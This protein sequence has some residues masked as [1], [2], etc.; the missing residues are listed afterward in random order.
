MVRTHILNAPAPSPVSSLIWLLW[1][2][3]PIENRNLL[4]TSYVIIYMR[5]ELGM[6]RVSACERL[7][8][9]CNI[10]SQS[11]T[12]IFY[13]DMQHQPQSEILQ[14]RVET[15]SSECDKLQLDWSGS[16]GCCRRDCSIDFFKDFPKRR[17]FP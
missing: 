8:I 15:T 12:K 1:G 5:Y 9:I 4:A 16:S 6:Y 3:E 17:G 2:W 11:C 10:C 7:V 14:S 13:R